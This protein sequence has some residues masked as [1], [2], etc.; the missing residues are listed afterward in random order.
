[1]ALVKGDIRVAHIIVVGNEKGGAGKSPVSML[2]ATALAR[3]GK[4]VG[5]MDL[6]LRQ[7]TVASYL[8]N[9][10]RYLQSI[11]LDLASP[12]YKPLVGADMDNPTAQAKEDALLRAVEALRPPS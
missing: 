5:V 2:L 6:D 12:L 3:M 11:E 1:V 8:D 10:T 4:I 9:R 7:K